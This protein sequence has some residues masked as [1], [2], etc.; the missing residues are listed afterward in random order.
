M[1]VTALAFQH[2]Q[3]LLASGGA[4]ALVGLWA[5]GLKQEP[6]ALEYLPAGV[7]QLAWSFDDK[8][9]AVGT[10]SGDVTVYSLGY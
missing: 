7:S 9:L 1:H 2:T 3:P 6:L 5:V 10:E 4:D 8:L